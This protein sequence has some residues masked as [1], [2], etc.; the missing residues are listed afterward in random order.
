VDGGRPRAPEAVKAAGRESGSGRPDDGHGAGPT[1]GNA[2]GLVIY[3]K[4]VRDTV[5]GGADA[6]PSAADALGLRFP[7][8]DLVASAAALFE[9]AQPWAHGRDRRGVEPESGRFRITVG[10]GVVRLAWTNPVRAEKASEQAVNRHRHDV[11][12]DVDGVKAGRD[13]PDPPE[14]VVNN[15]AAA[16]HAA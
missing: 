14:T 16:T 11:A 12:A 1:H 2:G 3:A 7:R 10:P 13:M 15:I 6:E 8:P 5:D 4:S 9:R